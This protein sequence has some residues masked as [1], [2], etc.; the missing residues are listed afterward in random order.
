MS[1]KIS[2]IFTVPIIIL[3]NTRVANEKIETPNKI[4]SV[5]SMFD[6]ANDSTMLLVY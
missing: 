5:I 6:S 1:S 4:N 2:N 3:Y